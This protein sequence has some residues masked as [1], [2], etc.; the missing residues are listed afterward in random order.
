MSS[1]SGAR[2]P[3]AVSIARRAP[4]TWAARPAGSPSSATPA[5]SA[6]STPAI[7]AGEPVLTRTNHGNATA[8]ISLPSVDAASAAPPAR[9]P[10][11]GGGGAPPRHSGDPGGLAPPRPPP[12]FS[13]GGPPSLLPL[14]GVRL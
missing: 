3:S 6:A 14:H 2:M 1:S 8:D 10:P 12:P 11:A 4:R 13:G 7:R 9:L 5:N